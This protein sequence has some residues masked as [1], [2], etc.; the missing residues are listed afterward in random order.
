MQQCAAVRRLHH[1]IRVHDAQIRIVDLEIIKFSLSYKLEFSLYDPEKRR[2]IW[3]YGY[4]SEIVEFV[5][6]QLF[7]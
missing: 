2:D 3:E 1:A 4:V 6:V 7:K 5:Q